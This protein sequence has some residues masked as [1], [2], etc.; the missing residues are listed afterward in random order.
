MLFSPFSPFIILSVQS[1]LFFASVLCH[2][3][4]LY[5]SNK[6]L[7][8]VDSVSLF[9]SFP[10]L[11]Q[12]YLIRFYCFCAFFHLRF[13]HLSPLTFYYFSSS[14]FRSSFTPIHRGPDQRQNLTIFEN[15]TQLF[16]SLMLSPLWYFAILFSLNLAIL[17]FTSSCRGIQSHDLETIL[18][19]AAT[20]SCSGLSK[21]Y[22]FPIRNWIF[23]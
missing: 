9:Q 20:L 8:E 21:P 14:I 11:F 10:A 16:S 12:L 13:L 23:V 7:F 3:F 15:K 5:L 1:N 19:F 17:F 6:L 4:F 18:P 22:S 2:R